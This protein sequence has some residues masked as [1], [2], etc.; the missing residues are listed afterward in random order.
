MKKLEKTKITTNQKLRLV[1]ILV[2]LTMAILRWYW[3][4]IIIALL[5]GALLIAE[6]PKNPTIMHR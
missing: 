2:F 3:V 1:L 4:A 5:L 6:K